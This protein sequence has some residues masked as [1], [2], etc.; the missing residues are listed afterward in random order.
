ML[1]GY[2]LLFGLLD[3][4]NTARALH[5]NNNNL[6]IYLTIA[7]WMLQLESAS[8]SAA[9]TAAAISIIVIDF[10]NILFFLDIIQQRAS[11]A[12][13]DVFMYLVAP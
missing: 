1:I 2:S 9:I 7:A 13:V 8:Y 3:I 6:Q 5:Q 4:I 12:I 11:S 10:T